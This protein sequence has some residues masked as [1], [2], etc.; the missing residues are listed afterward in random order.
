MHR[1]YLADIERGARNVTLRV[2][3]RLAIALEVPVEKLVTGAT[4]PIASPF[5]SGLNVLPADA[6]EILLVEDSAT[7]AALT[8]RA[9]KRANLTNRIRIVSD[10]EDGLHY[11]RG[12]GLYAQQ[13]PATPQLILLDLNLPGMSGLDFLRA[14][15]ADERIKGIRVV[16]LTASR[17]DLLLIESARLGAEHVLVKPL[18]IAGLVRVIPELNLF[19]TI[20]ALPTDGT[21]A[22]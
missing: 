20:V 3:A 10:G 13:L 6:G 14:I 18:T 21:K 8:V 12:T 19:L 5:H 15:K 4:A 11:L 1:T 7:D 17:R 16:V 22:A 9:F 2:L